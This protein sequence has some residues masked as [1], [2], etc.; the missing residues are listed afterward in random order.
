MD[1]EVSTRRPISRPVIAIVAVWLGLV[2]GLI[3]W[4]TPAACSEEVRTLEEEVAVLRA[5]IEALKEKGN[6]T[7][8]LE[9]KL[10][11]LAEEIERLKSGESPVEADRPQG[12]LAPAASKI[13]RTR[14]GVSLGGY[15][16]MLYQ[17]FDEKRDD[18]ANSN[19]TDSLDFVRAIAYLGY[20]FN[21]RFL[22]NSEI[23]FEHATTGQA[24]SVSVEFAYLDWQLREQANLRAGLLLVPMGFV[25]E[26]HEPTIFLGSRRPDV[27]RVILPTTWRENGVGLYGDVGPFSYRTYVLTGLEASG[28]SASGLR[29]GRQQGSE[30]VAEDFAWVG[31]LDFTGMPGLLVGAS[32]YFGDSG[33]AL[34]DARNQSIAVGT[35]IYELHAEW[36]WRALE[37]RALGAKAKLSDVAR[38]NAALSLTGNRSVGE[39]L[40]GYYLQ[41]GY[42][43]LASRGREQAL[44]PYLRYESFDTQ[45][46]VPAGFARNGANQVD[47]LTLGIAYRP[48]DR[49]IVKLDYQDLDNDAGTGID[50]LNVAIGYAF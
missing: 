14:Q 45:K 48:L 39:E 50:Q 37:V 20:K 34:R 38:L 30:S 3:G 9:R 11:V 36:K 33:Q 13:Y 27:E 7:A 29:G 47:S 17:R 40:E 31:R 22:F 32:T 26:L 19:R 43:L 10:D 23:E 21:D 42:D 1:H 18:G 28:F 35:E 6:A 24:G 16:E 5:E 2:G 41:A 46:A 4:T 15:G 8:E 49:L 12:G 44:L 25:N